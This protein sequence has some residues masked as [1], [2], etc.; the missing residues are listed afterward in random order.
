MILKNREEPI[1]LESLW[2]SEVQ[3]GR[4]NQRIMENCG[5]QTDQ[6]RKNVQE[7]PETS[8]DASNVR[9]PEGKKEIRFL[10]NP[11]PLPRKHEKRVL[12]YDYQVA[13]E[14]DFDI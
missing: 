11:L 14:D 3:E 7:Q 2:N 1:S 5:K 12:G 4:G 9:E 8:G 10:E 13:D 6:G